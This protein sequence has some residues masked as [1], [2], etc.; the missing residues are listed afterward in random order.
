MTE[1][2]STEKGV[3]ARLENNTIWHTWGNSWTELEGYSRFVTDRSGSNIWMMN[4]D[5]IDRIVPDKKS[6]IFQWSV[7]EFSNGTGMK[8]FVEG[9]S[10]VWQ[11]DRNKVVVINGSQTGVY[12]ASTD[13]WEVTHLFD[14]TSPRQF[15]VSPDYLA[16]LDEDKVW[17]INKN[18]KDY[19]IKEL[20]R[21]ARNVSIHFDRG[22]LQI[23]FMHDKQI[24]LRKWENPENS[25]YS[26][27]KRGGASAPDNFDPSQVI[28]A[29]HYEP[30]I[31]LKDESGKCVAYN[32]IMGTWR[33][34]ER[35]I[36]CDETESF[37]SDAEMLLESESVKIMRKNGETSYEMFYNNSWC[38]MT[39]YPGGFYE[40]IV[41]DRQMVPVPPVQI[42]SQ[43]KLTA[44][45]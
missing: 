22:I 42:R 41:E 23:A 40:D 30:S 11:T 12:D 24:I 5:G 3:F 4:E 18:L 34:V 33:E 29:K 26:E 45:G 20:P 19:F 21:D 37:H 9:A 44:S 6:P 31:F 17:I 1:I 35:N 2:Q 25:R 28:Y 38:E 43:M 27:Y 10:F 15:A 14:L 16:V 13:N 39:L 36:F 7:S 32:Y 8:D